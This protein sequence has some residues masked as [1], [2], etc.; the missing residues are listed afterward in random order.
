M[1]QTVFLTDLDDTLFTSRQKGDGTGAQV[2]TAKN[3]HHSHMSGPQDALFRL[4]LGSG[5]VIPVT[6]RSSDAFARVHLSFGTGR[7]ILANGAVILDETGNPDPDWAARTAEIGQRAGGVMGSMCA[8]ITEEYGEAARVWVVREAGA[9]VYFCL[10]MNSEDPARVAGALAEA[11]ELLMDR[12]DLSGFRQHVNGNNLSFTPDGISKGD[13]T[14]HL[15]GLLGDRSDLSLIGVGDSVTDL[16][17][18]ELCDFMIT[19]SAS[20][21]AVSLR[22]RSR[23]GAGS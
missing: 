11:G 2:T 13:A 14:A 21:I 15:I 1:R 8:L 10:K 12:F 18:M 23:T 9:P 5:L 16:P 6:A 3:G 22:G 19:P 17:F 4:M 7:A 20:Q